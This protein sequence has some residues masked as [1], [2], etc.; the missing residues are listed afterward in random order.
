LNGTLSKS[1]T[2]TIVPNFSNITSIKIG[3]LAGAYKCD[4]LLNDFRIYDHCLSA[5]EVKEIA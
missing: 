4:C 5:A 1:G 2:T 3:G